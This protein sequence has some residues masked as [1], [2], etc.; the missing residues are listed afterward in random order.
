MLM[1]KFERFKP[2]T[3]TDL[4]YLKTSP[5]Y[6]EF[7]VKK[8]SL[9][10]HG[11][12]CDHVSCKKKKSHH[13]N[14]IFFWPSRKEEVIFSFL[15]MIITMGCCYYLQRSPGIDGCELMCCMRGYTTR[16]EKRV[17]R[18]KCKFHWCCFVKCEECYREVEVST[19]NWTFVKYLN[20]RITGIDPGRNSLVYW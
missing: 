14:A 11:R 16:R 1:P 12:E 18:C 8:G 4:V 17:E 7:D 5:D 2:H 15:K 3:D 9:G 19:C 6:C 20:S 13:F 10:T